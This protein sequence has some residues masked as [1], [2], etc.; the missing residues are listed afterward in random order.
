VAEASTGGLIAAELTRLPGSSAYFAGGLVAYDHHSKTGT[1][2]IP[3]EVFDHVGS[4]S[5][6]ACLAMASAARRLFQA[7]IGLAE[8]GIAGPGGAV[9][10][11][12]VGV[13]YAAVSSDTGDVVRENNFTGDRDHNRKSAVEAAL[14]LLADHL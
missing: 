9:A 7:G 10:G 8:T 5:A 1:L 2:G 12:P 13:S 4:V 6:E 11:K 3:I 14:L